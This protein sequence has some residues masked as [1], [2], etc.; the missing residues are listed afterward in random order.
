MLQKSLPVNSNPEEIWSSF[1][2]G[3]WIMARL[4][5]LRLLHSF[6]ILLQRR[7]GAGILAILLWGCASAL[8]EESKSWRLPET[9]VSELFSKVPP[10]GVH[11]RI[12]ISPEDLPKLRE[13]LTDTE[14]GRHITSLL[15]T[16][17]ASLSKKDAQ[18][19][20]VYERLI[21]GDLSA[22][23]SAENKRAKNDIS[24]SLCLESL[25]ALV[26]DDKVRGEKV[27]AAL[28][29][30][31][32][33]THAIEIGNP[34]TPDY[35]VSYAYDFA[36]LFMTE[37]QRS[38][39]R[40]EISATIKGQIPFGADLAPSNC[41]FNFIPHGT[42]LVLMQLAIEGEEGDDASIYPKAVAAMKKFLDN[43]IYA[44]GTPYEDM[45]YFNFGMNW[46]APAMVAFARRGDNLFANEHYRKLINWYAQAMEPFGQAFST[47]QDTPNDKGG[48]VP[49]Y[50]VM[51]WVWPNDPLVDFVWK[52]RI[53]AD[54]TQIRDWMPSLPFLALFA[55]DFNSPPPSHEGANDPELPFLPPSFWSPERG[56]F[57]TRDAWKKDA[58]VL[59]FLIN[60]NLAEP[61]HVHS[62]SNDISLSGLG[63]KWV[64]DRGFRRAESKEH[65]LV[66]IDGKGQGFFPAPGK[67]VEYQH[68]AP[69]DLIC[70]D[71]SYSYDWLYEWGNRVNPK[72][73]YLQ[74]FQFEP[75][76]LAP[77][78]KIWAERTVEH[79]EKPWEDPKLAGAYTYKAS[80]NPVQKAFRTAA[81]RR[82][83][84]SY[85]L[86]VD[87]I[88]KDDQAH[89]YEWLLQLPDDL[90]I[91]K[92]NH[93]E[94]VLGS[95]QADDPRQM[96]VRMIGVNTED[97]KGKWILED[98]DIVRSPYTGSTEALGKGRRLRYVCRAVEPCFRVLLSIYRD[99]DALPQTSIDAKSLRVTWPDQDDNFKIH[100]IKGDRTKINLVHPASR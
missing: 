40:E 21:A 3:R 30:Y 94:V 15:E 43:G 17:P 100:P 5:L 96:L 20:S 77:V 25:L 84:H 14:I 52:N 44:N 54:Y 95:T 53:R 23:D 11:P 37:A 28:A 50:C 60:P 45:H 2:L 12:L 22:M 68:S 62:N 38:A 18:G 72:V 87:D 65:S 55:R 88:R 29:T 75:E 49:N 66:L 6:R 81:F 33:I 24:T 83:L 89:D 71:A 58:V 90:E 34:P 16:F 92:S 36:Y 42:S 13:R 19:Q 56:L 85:V 63:R 86:I 26:R 4:F 91:R 31:A 64:I 51:K 41:Y 10:P 48:L 57:I 73:P 74:E 99:G 7:L 67:V 9:N 80:Y 98:Y 69:L 78:V 93:G 97:G 27:G 47:H 76:T 46:G 8:G 35:L 61:S 32:R 82:A 79:K 39:V 70:G 59:H 1:V